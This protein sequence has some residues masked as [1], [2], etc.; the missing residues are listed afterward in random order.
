MN[1]QLFFK[2]KSENSHV[3]S[4][5]QIREKEKRRD[6]PYFRVVYNL[7]DLF[8]LLDSDVFAFFYY[9]VKKKKKNYMTRNQ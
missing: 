6:I 9:F 5:V 1:F 4:S 3:F 7:L 2:V 8:T